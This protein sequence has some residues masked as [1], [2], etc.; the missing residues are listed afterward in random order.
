MSSDLSM[1]TNKIVS[2]GAP[3]ADADAATKKYVD[4]EVEAFVGTVGPLS[5]DKT[6]N[7]VGSG[8]FISDSDDVGGVTYNSTNKYIL[9]VI[10]EINDGTPE[11]D[12][13]IHSG[14]NSLA[15]M[16]ISSMGMGMDI[17]GTLTCVLDGALDITATIT[18]PIL[19]DL[20]YKLIQIG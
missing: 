7:I 12:L 15:R 13:H 19:A 1:G 6:T 2:L 16:T 18:P 17:Y 8:V 3:T 9:I 14:S 5:S 20:T 11:V 4:D 10:G